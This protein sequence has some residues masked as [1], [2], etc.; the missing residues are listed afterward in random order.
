MFLIAAT[1]KSSKA[2]SEESVL[3]KFKLFQLL[4]KALL[5][6]FKSS[7]DIL[8]NLTASSV[9]FNGTFPKKVTPIVPISLRKVTKGF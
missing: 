5:V 4:S 8:F 2:T 7:T 1:K 3:T 9:L 6:N